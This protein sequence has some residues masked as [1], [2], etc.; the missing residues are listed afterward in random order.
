[1][2]Q[3]RDLKRHYEITKQTLKPNA[4]SCEISVRPTPLSDEY[5]LKVVFRQDPYN[6]FS[7]FVLKPNPLKL[8]KGEIGLPHV[9]NTK[10][11]ELCLYRPKKREWNNTMFLS[12]TAIPWAVEWLYFYEVW[13]CT[14]EWFG[15]GEH[16]PP[17]KMP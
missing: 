10:K 4:F 1:M 14:G 2:E 16:P 6:P 7:V 11:Q 15:E 8:A 13:L 9:Y 3:L 5:I 17:K 12:K